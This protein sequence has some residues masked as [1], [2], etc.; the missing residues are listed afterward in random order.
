MT[1]P[2]HIDVMNLHKGR[3]NQQICIICLILTSSQT[4]FPNACISASYL[5]KFWKANKAMTYI[6]LVANWQKLATK[7]DKELHNRI[8]GQLKKQPELSSK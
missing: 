3:F 2:K 6:I 7:Q 5:S 8:R 4:H 1:N